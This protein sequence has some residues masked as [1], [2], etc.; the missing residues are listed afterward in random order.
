[1]A[2]ERACKLLEE[3]A[4]AKILPGTVK[5]DKTVNKEKE[6]EIEYQFINNVLG[7]EISKEDILDT[8]RKLKFKT[9][10]KGES[11]LVIVPFSS[12]SNFTSTVIV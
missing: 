4:E 12:L 2:I 9:E 6:I 8:F 10:D 7:A 5:Y 1:M 11:A 3:Y